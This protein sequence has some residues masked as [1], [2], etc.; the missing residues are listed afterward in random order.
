MSTNFAMIVGLVDQF[1]KCNF[2]LNFGLVWVL[3][4][5]VLH[6]KLLKRTAF[7]N[8]FNSIVQTLFYCYRFLRSLTRFYHATMFF[9][10]QVGIIA[11][12]VSNIA[13]T[14]NSKRRKSL[15]KPGSVYLGCIMSLESNFYFYVISTQKIENRALILEQVL[16]QNLSFQ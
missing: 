6:S 3:A 8:N 11:K 10:Y 1:N 15:H 7:I 12:S 13:R 2:N 4:L 9:V 5:R 16:N 14:L